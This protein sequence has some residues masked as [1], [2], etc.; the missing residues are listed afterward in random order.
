[1]SD[2]ETMVSTAKEEP[3]V[4]QELRMFCA[5]MRDQK[6]NAGAD[7]NQALYDEAVD[8]VVA[9]LRNKLVEGME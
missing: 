2:E 8:L 5:D 7:F 4:L 3:R 1:M 9:R 6:L